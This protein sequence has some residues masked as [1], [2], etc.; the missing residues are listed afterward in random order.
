MIVSELLFLSSLLLPALEN[1]VLGEVASWEGWRVTAIAIWALSDVI[2]DPDFILL[3]AAGLGNL[4]FLVA[5]WLLFGKPSRSKLRALTG[6]VVVAFMLALWAPYLPGA[7][8]TKL[9]VGYF[10]W[11]SAYAALLGSV[12]LFQFDKEVPDKEVGATA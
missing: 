10:T 2:K 9:L 5:P 12:L 3:G 11:L 7:G 4:V 1:V 6:A 8:S